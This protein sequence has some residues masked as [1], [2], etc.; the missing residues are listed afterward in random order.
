MSDERHTRC[1]VC[2]SCAEELRAQ[3]AAALKTT[4]LGPEVV[5]HIREK[6]ERAREWCMAQPFGYSAWGE[7]TE[8]L[9][10]LPRPSGPQAPA[11]R[12]LALTPEA[13]A[14][15]LEAL[16]FIRN[17][18][19]EDGFDPMADDAGPDEDPRNAPWN[20]AGAALA[21]LQERDAYRTTTDSRPD[22]ITRPPGNNRPEELLPAA[23]GPQAPSMC[24]CVD[25]WRVDPGCPFKDRPSHKPGAAAASNDPEQAMEEMAALADDARPRDEGP[26]PV[27]AASMDAAGSAQARGLR[28]ES[29]GDQGAGPHAEDCAYC[30]VGVPHGSAAAPD[31]GPGVPVVEA[32]SLLDICATNCDHD[33]QNCKW[34]IDGLWVERTARDEALVKYVLEEAATIANKPLAEWATKKKLSDAT[35]KHIR[36]TIRSLSPSALAREFAAKGEKP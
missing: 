14:P 30:S 2:T 4:A 13:L 36:D 28:G 10:L 5:G 18:L 22:L 24:I 8:V 6:L 25:P 20:A 12:V 35:A 3:G 17:W 15:V 26:R 11:K 9:G 33:Y 21:M 19:L 34:T 1:A 31:A 23:S 32:E 29:A 27:T 16:E 7:V